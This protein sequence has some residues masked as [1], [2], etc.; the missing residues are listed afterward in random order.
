MLGSEADSRVLVDTKDF[1]IAEL[2]GWLKANDGAHGALVTFTGMVRDLTD[3]AIERLYLEHYPGMTEKALYNIIAQARSH[4]SLGRVAVYHRV[5]ALD[6]GDN[7]VF[8]GVSSA[9]RK[10]AFDAAQFLM[11]YL[12]RDAPFWKKE[13]S[14]EGENWVAQ[15]ESDMEAAERWG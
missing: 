12:K 9:H 15:K 11:D 5:G 10:E 4:W 6:A 8:V 3:S 7:I 14:A 2:H 1:D 13:V